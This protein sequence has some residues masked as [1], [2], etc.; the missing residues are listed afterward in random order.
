MRDEL[1][2]AGNGLNELIKQAQSILEQYLIPDRKT[3]DEAIDDLLTLFDGPKQREVQ[4]NWDKA[5][6]AARS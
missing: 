3:A 1:I 4:D 2:E 6:N 5:L